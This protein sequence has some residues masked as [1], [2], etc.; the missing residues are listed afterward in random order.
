MPIS[1][2]IL[3]LNEE[4]NLAACLESVKWSDDVVVVDSFSSDRTVEIARA[5][6]A[7]VVQRA[8]DNF[9]AQRNFGLREGGL[10]H[11][12]VLHLDADER[13]TPELHQ[14]LLE[15]IASDPKDAYRVA[16]KTMLQGRWLKHAGMY[17][18]YQV[19]F[20]RKETLLFQ[21]VGHGQREA[22]SPDRLGT[23]RSPLI[24]YS[25][26]K[27]ITDWVE[28]HNRYSTDEAAYALEGLAHGFDR[29]GLFSLSDPTRQRR[30]LKE[31]SRRVPFRPLLRFLY[32]YVWRRGFLD[33]RAGLTYA[34]LLATYEYLTVL[35]T[36]EMQGAR[37]G[38]SP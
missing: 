9:A 21:Q 26:S 23:L 5:A 22:I 7:R 12:W 1:V 19:R 27:G 15:V 2:L 20:G 35:K 30:A 24:H 18:S 17:P 6:G 31:L 36:R 10:R 28:R 25:F 4:A 8:F 32:S 16:S 29:R 33:G 3:T 38:R 37:Q 13:V 34:R 11:P 14:N